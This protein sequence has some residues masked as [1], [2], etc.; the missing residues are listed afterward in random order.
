VPANAAVR[1]RITPSHRGGQR[2][3][4]LS[5]HASPAYRD[6]PQRHGQDEHQYV[7]DGRQL[8]GDL[9][10]SRH[11]R[12]R[13]ADVRRDLV[14]D[15]MALGP[16]SLCA[17]SYSTTAETTSGRPTFGDI[18]ATQKCHEP[19]SPVRGKPGIVDGRLLQ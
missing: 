10:S 3:W 6:R 17:A 11:Q 1:P 2:G 5:V 15:V 19:Q 8:G 14:I 4:V 9:P 13:Q 12:R 18:T 7:P 16:A